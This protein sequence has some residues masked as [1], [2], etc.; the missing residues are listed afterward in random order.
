M[1]DLTILNDCFNFG[2]YIYNYLSIDC[3]LQRFSTDYKMIMNYKNVNK[4][5]VYN[6]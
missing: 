6:N 1:I 3:I 4:K 2:K 5:I